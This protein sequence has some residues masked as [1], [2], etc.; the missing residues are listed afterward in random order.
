MWLAKQQKREI[1]NVLS[2][3]GAVTIGG[4]MPA[5][6][7][8]SERRDLVVYAPGGYR[9]RPA[10]GQKVLVLKADGQPCIAGTPAEGGLSPGEV[11]LCSAG[12]A[13]LKLDNSGNISVTGNLVVG[14]TGLTQLIR[15]VVSEALSEQGG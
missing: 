13:R 2:A 4:D 12:G 3:V 15:A 1:E 6:E 9:W 8:D 14:G 7:L 11:E 5:V 10:P